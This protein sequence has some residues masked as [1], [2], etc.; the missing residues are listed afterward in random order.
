MIVLTRVRVEQ[1]LA[2]DKR[3]GTIAEQPLVESETTQLPA[4]RNAS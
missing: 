4:E 2:E 3:T 1:V